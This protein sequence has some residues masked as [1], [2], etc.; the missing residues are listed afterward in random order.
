MN[1]KYIGTVTGRTRIRPPKYTHYTLIR[2]ELKY[3]FP[4]HYKI[5]LKWVLTKRKAIG[6]FSHLPIPAA[7]AFCASPARAASSTPLWNDHNLSWSD[8][9]N[10]FC[11]YSWTDLRRRYET[12][13]A[14][15]SKRS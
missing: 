12:R 7:M 10:H 1:I 5:L 11:G 4:E 13:H 9:N 15:N 2:D 3:H 14:T 6:S 8:L